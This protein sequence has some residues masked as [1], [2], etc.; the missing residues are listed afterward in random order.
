[1]NTLGAMTFITPAAALVNSA[2]NVSNANDIDLADR[3][4]VTNGDIHKKKIT[5]I[6]S[7]S[8]VVSSFMLPRFNSITFI[9]NATD[10]V[11]GNHLTDANSGFTNNATNLTFQKVQTTHAD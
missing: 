11:Y 6:N 10:K 2:L 4:L 9:K 3:V 1:M 5:I 7:S 8:E